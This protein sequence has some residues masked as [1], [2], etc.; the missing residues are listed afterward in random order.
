MQGIKVAFGVEISQYEG[1]I[2]GFDLVESLRYYKAWM[3]GEFL[4]LVP[5][6]DRAAGREGAA[7]AFKQYSKTEPLLQDLP[8]VLRQPLLSTMEQVSCIISNG[9]Y[10]KIAHAFRCEHQ[11]AIAAML[12]ASASTTQQ[13]LPACLSYFTDVVSV[14]GQPNV[15]QATA[16]SYPSFLEA[17]SAIELQ[18]GT[19]F[20]SDHREV[21][22]GELVLRQSCMFGGKA[23]WEER[24]ARMGRKRDYFKRESSVG[25]S[26]KCKC[27]AC[28]TASI[29]IPYA[30]SLKLMAVQQT[31]QQ[32]A[33]A[34]DSTVRVNINLGH[35]GHKP[36]SP[37]DL[38]S[39][40][41]HPK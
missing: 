41:T 26:V 16:P 39:L 19:H 6:Y 22:G 10:S 31:D 34:L 29:S 30:R 20:N 15:Y 7:R 37:A 8:R 2:S 9:V 25:H 38:I 27:P 17:L 5:D 33:A 36:N 23:S 13:H 28:I 14:A 4:Q 32:A 40:P 1:G 3:R 35:V 12:P 11:S 18:T 24:T 21:L